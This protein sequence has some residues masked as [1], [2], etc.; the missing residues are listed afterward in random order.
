MSEKVSRRSLIVG[1]G[2]VSAAAALHGVSPAVAAGPPLPLAGPVVPIFPIR[3]YDSRTDTAILGGRKLQH[4][5]AVSVNVG[6][7]YAQSPSGYAAAVFGNLTI[8]DTEGS[9]YLTVVPSDYSDEPPVPVHSNIN[10]WTSGVIMANSFLSLVGAEHSIDIR[11]SV[12]RTHVVID[13]FGF[14]PLEIP[15]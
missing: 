5:D 7:A 8:T 13:A 10:W 1:A 3:L 4:G 2:T 14:I 12:G 6:Q 9:G 11:C 15:A